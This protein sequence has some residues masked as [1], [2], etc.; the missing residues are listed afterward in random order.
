MYPWTAILAANFPPI[1]VTCRLKIGINHHQPSSRL[2]ETPNRTLS[3]GSRW[4]SA[5]TD[6]AGNSTNREGASL[7][8]N[9]L[10]LV[11]SLFFY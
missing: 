9:E 6:Q 8:K 2:G 3:T 5:N 1:A 11:N 7:V 4:C 10:A